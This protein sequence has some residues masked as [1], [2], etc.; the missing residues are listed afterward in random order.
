MANFNSMKLTQQGLNMQTQLQFGGTIT[1][2]KVFVGDGKLPANA[3]MTSLTGLISPVDADISIVGNKILGNGKI[4]LKARLKS[5]KRSFYMRE[6]GIYA[7][8]NN[9]PPVLYAYGYS[10]DTAD[11]I[12]AVGGATYIVQ[13]LNLI[14][15]IGNAETVSANVTAEIGV[16]RAEF[17]AH[18]IDDNNPHKVTKAQ[19]GLGNVDNTSDANKPVSTAAQTALNGKVDKVSG[20]GLSTNDYTTDEKNK[21]A[22]I[23][24]GAEVNVRATRF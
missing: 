13:D 17:D 11:F 12:P 2:T 20:K 3:D 10:G 16:E 18:L 15:V 19:V 8:F 23:A 4:N 21:L 1:F 6:I 24:E 9:N 14:T 5:G 22:G 7:K